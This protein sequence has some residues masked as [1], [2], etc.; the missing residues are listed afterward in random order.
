MISAQEKNYGDH[1]YRMDEYDKELLKVSALLHDIGH[2]PLSH[3]IELALKR[4]E[5]EQ[6]T[7]DNHIFEKQERN[8][9]KSDKENIAK[10]IQKEKN[11]SANDTKLHE[12]LGEHVLRYTS[13][14]QTLGEFS[15][16]E[17]ASVFKG[18]TGEISKKKLNV[19]TSLIAGR[20]FLHSQLDADRIDYLLRDSNFTG[21]KSGAIDFDKL[22]DEIR[23]DQEGYF[24]INIDGIR[25]LEQ[26]FMARFAAY[27]QIPFNKH[28]HAFDYMA[29]DFYYRLLKEKENKPDKLK[30]VYD[31]RELIR[32]L[33]TTPGKFL[34]FTD[35]YFF[36]LVEKVK[37]DYVTSDY[38]I[39]QYAHLLAEGKPLKVVDYYERFCSEK[40]W[41]NR[42]SLIKKAKECREKLAHVAGVEIEDI[43]IPEE[44][45]QVKIIE[46]KKDPIYVFGNDFKPKNILDCEQSFLRSL[47]GKQLFVERM[48]TF[49]EEKQKRIKEAL[50][51]E[52]KWKT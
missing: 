25:A 11:T 52:G 9:S 4:Y 29:S 27:T 47:R 28:V 36:K 45:L 8:T 42:D 6:E 24:G 37:N 49:D 20:N 46:E 17:V 50:R 26:F 1:A 48:F 16:E 19:Q 44:P 14:G 3:T 21:V 15:V 12:R 18:F 38:T 39:K 40:E 51:Q 10:L 13:L 43:I 31:Y 33:K 23:Y 2:L 34:E 41:K 35:N 32:I 7:S 30:D 22:L 5:K